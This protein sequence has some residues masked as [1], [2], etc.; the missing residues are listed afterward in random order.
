M[1][2]REEGLGTFRASLRNAGMRQFSVLTAKK[3]KAEEYAMARAAGKNASQF[4]G[5]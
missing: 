1:E 2:D 3:K 4:Y 5:S